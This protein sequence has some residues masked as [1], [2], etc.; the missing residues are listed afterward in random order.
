MS[1][2]RTETDA[3]KRERWAALCLRVREGLSDLGFRGKSVQ[4]PFEGKKSRRAREVEAQEV[5]AWIAD[6]LHKARMSLKGVPHSAF[7][8][9]LAS[10]FSE[11]DATKFTHE[12]CMEAERRH[13]EANRAVEVETV[14]WTRAGPRKV[15]HLVPAWRVPQ[16]EREAAAAAQ[17][18]AREAAI[19]TAKRE[20]EQATKA[21]F[22]K[23]FADIALSEGRFLGYCELSGAM[24][25]DPRP[26]W[27]YL[28]LGQDGAI[29]C[30]STFRLRQRVR[31][32]RLGKG[33][34]ITADRRQAWHLLHA[35]RLANGEDGLATE[36]ALLRS[37]A[38]R[39]ALL[40]QRQARA[41][42]LQARHG[43]A[44]P[45]LNPP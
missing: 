33:A 25:S 44:V 31:A 32:H 9:W 22:R 10:T 6:R 21:A 29:Y 14:V 36:H 39:R 16:F 41:L 43:C 34:K 27:V 23:A 5:S 26:R 42:K 3:E 13:R 28:L 20:A 30:G 8:A 38:L 11:K 15:R 19:Q 17:A 12:A 2:T 1:E 18:A 24:M 37:A 35:E 7:D 40:A 45:W 4:T